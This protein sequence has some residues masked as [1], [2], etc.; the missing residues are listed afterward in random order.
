MAMSRPQAVV[1]S[2][3]SAVAAVVVGA[4]LW[5]TLGEDA[6]DNGDGPTRM[7]SDTSAAT[8][9][10]PAGGDV[11]ATTSAAEETV[12]PT[13]VAGVAATVD[14]RDVAI[15][16]P[17]DELAEPFVDTRS[18][19]LSA[20]EDPDQ[21]EVFSVAEGLALDTLQST[22]TEYRERGWTQTGRPVVVSTQVTDSDPNADPPQAVLDVC[23]D[24]A[25]V[26]VL[27]TAGT[28]V[29][30]SEAQNRVLNVFEMEY[31]DGRWVLVEQT[32][33]DDTTC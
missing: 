18:E 15:K 30:D 17:A 7:A 6:T 8:G 27:D 11:S 5:S 9:T 3:A 22:A 1:V 20:P 4:V 13:V 12:A 33:G 16:E 21:D 32:F 14:P 10:G 23:L 31:Q 29:V 28:S 2:G 26:D 25:G 19:V 24:F